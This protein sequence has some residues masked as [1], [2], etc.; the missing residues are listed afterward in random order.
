MNASCQKWNP[1]SAIWHLCNLR[2]VSLI[3]HFSQEYNAAYKII[4]VLYIF[5]GNCEIEF[6]RMSVF[7]RHSSIVVRQTEGTSISEVACFMSIDYQN[8]KK[9]SVNHARGKTKLTF[10][11]F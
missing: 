7:L 10:Y 4:N 1:S 5:Y 8:G 3:S 6:I 11:S 9:N 2:H